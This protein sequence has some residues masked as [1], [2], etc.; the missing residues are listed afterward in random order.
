MSGQQWLIA[1]VTSGSSRFLMTATSTYT[2]TAI[3]I[4]NFTAFSDVP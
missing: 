2:D 3:H 4:W 1:I